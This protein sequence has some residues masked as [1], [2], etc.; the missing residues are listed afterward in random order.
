MLAVLLL[1]PHRIPDLYVASSHQ[2]Q[3]P[4]DIQTCHHAKGPKPSTHLRHKIP[5]LVKVL[6]AHQSKSVRGAIL[7]TIAIHRELR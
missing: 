4:S 5:N 3:H 2:Q 6:R 7:V 1:D